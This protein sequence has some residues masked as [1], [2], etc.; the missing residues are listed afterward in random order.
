MLDGRLG[1]DKE[2]E[3]SRRK[4]TSIVACSQNWGRATKNGTPGQMNC[5]MAKEEVKKLKSHRLGQVERPRLTSAPGEISQQKS[6]FARSLRRMPKGW[7][8][9]GTGEDEV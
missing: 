4:T 1:Q 7:F 5:R 6:L 2:R 9:E 8:Q 3:R